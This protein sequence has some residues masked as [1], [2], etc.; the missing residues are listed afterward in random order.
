MPIKRNNLPPPIKI[1]MNKRFN[2]EKYILKFMNQTHI[3]IIYNDIGNLKK[4]E[5]TIITNDNIRDTFSINPMYLSVYDY[6]YKDNN[7][8]L[9][10]DVIKINNI[11]LENGTK[12]NLD[13]IYFYKSK[14]VSRRIDSVYNINTK[15]YWFQTDYLPFQLDIDG[16]LD[17]ISKIEDNILSSGD[18]EGYN[19]L[20]Y[21]RFLT[22]ESALI[23]KYLHK[24][25]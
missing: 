20:K 9:Q 2:S 12:K 22:L 13:N 4:L 24:I 25:I 16:S 19:V 3:N 21:G 7:F 1:D 10:Y 8:N 23:S 14:G 11:V 17:R 18:N 15:D 6:F 5:Y